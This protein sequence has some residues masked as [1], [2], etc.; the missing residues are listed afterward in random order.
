MA[1]AVFHKSQRV[2]VRPI[3]TWAHIEHV[4]PKWAKGISEPIKIHYDVGLGRPFTCD[5]LEAEDVAVGRQAT[6]HGEWRVLRGQNKW[7]AAD[8]CQHP[9]YPGTHPIIT[10]GELDWGGWRVPG[11]EYDRDPQ[12]IEQ[13]ALMIVK[14]PVMAG[15]LTE[16]V[17]LLDENGDDIPSPI[18]DIAQRARKQLIDAGIDLQNPGG[19]EHADQQSSSPASARSTDR[20]ATEIPANVADKAFDAEMNEPVRQPDPMVPPPAEPQRQPAQNRA[21][22]RSLAPDPSEFH[23]PSGS[24]ASTR[25]ASVAVEEHPDPPRAIAQGWR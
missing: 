10:T 5:E 25:P 22:F 12:R 1:K 4:I 24:A 7:R 18:T 16:L 3:G 2:F 19:N 6:V 11:T 23:T 13:Q 14:A 21:I 8:E 9:P 15:L 20:P 17:R